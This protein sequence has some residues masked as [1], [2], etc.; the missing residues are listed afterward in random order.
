MITQEFLDCE[1]PIALIS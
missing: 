1:L